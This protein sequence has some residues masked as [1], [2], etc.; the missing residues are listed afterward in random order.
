VLAGD[1]A[2]AKIV[3]GCHLKLCGRAAVSENEAS[4]SHYLLAFEKF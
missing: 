2:D 3:F 4:S 1:P